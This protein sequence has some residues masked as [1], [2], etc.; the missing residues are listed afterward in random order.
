MSEDSPLTLF[1]AVSTADREKALKNL[2]E[3]KTP[4]SAIFKR[5][6][7]GGNEV[8]YVKTYYMT[9]EIGLVTGFRWSSEC[10]EEK[11]YPSE[12]NLKEVGA[13]MKVTVW[14]NQGNCY[15]HAS[16]GGKEVARWATD[17]F[18]KHGNQVA[19]QGDII[20]FFDDMKSAYSDGI[21]K[22]LSYFGIAN[23][24]YGGKELE[25]FS[26]DVE[27]DTK[28]S[29]KA[30]GEFLGK[31]KILPSTASEVMGVAEFSQITDYKEAYRLLQLWLKSG[32]PKGENLVAWQKEVMS[33]I[34]RQPE[35]SKKEGE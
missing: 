31:H 9:R 2:I 8:N 24:V 29:Y 12:E 23:D 21:K 19:K 15:S 17:R 5:K 30:F 18:D 28:D 32:K 27:L 1:E 33:S 11:F 13:R 10:L 3:G 7:R 34:E 35:D 14:D 6:S 4:P 26:D 22:C 20:S 25:Y 16:W